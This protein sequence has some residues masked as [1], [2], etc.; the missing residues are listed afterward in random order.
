MSNMKKYLITAI[1]LGCIAMCAGA[2][3]GATNL[4][5]KDHIAQNE[6][7]KIND[8]FAEVF[9]DG[10]NGNEDQN[11][12]YKNYTY[13]KAKYIILDAS[14]AEIGS[15]YR[16]LGSNAY[17]KISLII[18]FTNDNIYKGLSVVTNEQSFATTLEE[19][20]LDPLKKGERELEDVKCGATYGATLVKNMVDEATKAAKGQ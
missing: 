10:A 20:Y 4:I 15:A 5:T 9:G 1:T 2:L 19:N 8:G 6:A 11:F 17:G 3:I 7:K 16:T 14:G 18:G 12:E 13:L